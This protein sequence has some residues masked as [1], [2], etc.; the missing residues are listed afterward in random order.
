MILLGLWTLYLGGRTYLRNPDWH[1]QRTFLEKT[2]ADGGDSARMYINLGDLEL[3]EGHTALAIGDFQKAMT[4]TPDQPFALIS[5][6]SAYLH[7][8]EYELAREEFMKALKV[9]ITEAD[10][11]QAL[12]VLEYQEN[13][14]DRLDLLEKAARLAPED[15]DI[16]KRLILH[17]GEIGQVDHAIMLL[18]SIITAEPWRGDT[19][20]VLGDFWAHVRQWDSAERAYRRAIA[21]D[22]HDDET[23][24]KLAAVE[25]ERTQ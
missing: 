18:R 23:P 9:P 8:K 14:T 17:L 22:V 12:A 20:R 25:D 21:L 6:G 13:R 5:L 7:D 11:Y 1:D 2:S 19:W 16:Q 10:A 24:K 3:T 15:W 4:L